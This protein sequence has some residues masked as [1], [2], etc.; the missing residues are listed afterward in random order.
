[1]WSGSRARYHDQCRRVIA[2]VNTAVV[3]SYRFFINRLAKC[4]HTIEKTNC[5]EE[6]K[7]A[8]HRLAIEYCLFRARGKY[9]KRYIFLT[10]FYFFSTFYSIIRIHSSMIPYLSERRSPRVLENY[11]KPTFQY[12]MY[13]TPNNSLK[14]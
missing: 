13:P 11:R 10:Y 2:N 5:T 12:I 6:K 14:L 9:G 1:M 4:A 8:I 3:N 7:H